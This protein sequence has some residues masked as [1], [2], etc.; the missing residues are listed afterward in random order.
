MRAFLRADPDINMVGEMRDPETTRIAVEASL[1]GH[2]VLSTLHTNSA[3][4]SVV[5]L[6]DM[7]LDP[8]NF[9]DALLGVLGQRLAR[10]L[11][12]DCKTPMA[13]AAE[14][15]QLMAEEYCR[16][17]PLVATEVLAGWR[18]KY[19]ASGEGEPVLYQPI[20]CARCHNSGYRGRVGIYELM[21]ASP[22][23]K[24]LI[25]QRRPVDE[26]FGQAMADGMLRL[27]QYGAHAV[28]QG[29]TDWRSIRSAC[30]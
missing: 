27:Q 28:L 12:A 19:G 10:R 9:A 15:L 22:A 8:F 1:T 23:I 4:E 18:V 24:R 21:S 16:Q 3:P 20:G 29:L 25:Q 26:L 14:Q 17:T 7:G 5:R 30:A 13:D 6:L 11:C 2:L